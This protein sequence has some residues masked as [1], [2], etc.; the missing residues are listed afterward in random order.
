MAEFTLD[1]RSAIRSVGAAGSL[2]MLSAVARAASDEG[3]SRP[4]TDPHTR[5]VYAAIVDA[6]VPRTPAVAEELGRA[7]LP[8]GLEV[9]LDAYLIAYVND[10]FSGLTRAG[11]RSGDLRLAES[12]ALVL[13][14]AATE[15]VARGKNE[16]APSARYALDLRDR[17]TI[18]DDA[19]DVA[20]AGLFPRLSRRDRLNALTLLDEKEIDTAA[21]ADRTPVPLFESDGGF[22]P[23]L[24]VGFTE[25]VYYS[26]WQGYDDF[27]AAP[28]E[29]SFA[30]NPAAVQSW[31]QSG[32]PGV[33][34]GYRA[35][36]GYWGRPNSSLGEGRVWKRVDGDRGPPNTITLESGEFRDNDYDTSG[37]EEPFPTGGTDGEDPTVDV[38]GGDT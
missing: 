30:D 34:D 24:V 21:L 36:R 32:F 28:S 31:R 33:A 2:S 4:D 6:V 29:R 27:T 12:V 37:Y 10:L 18:V 1:R 19:V 22:V 38:G 9:G 3:P 35:F 20:A 23:T 7:H 25:L 17:S 5:L 11:D 16:D 15:L 13:E 8:G 26:E 14:E